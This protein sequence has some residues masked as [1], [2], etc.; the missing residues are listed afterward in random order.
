M[1]DRHV[2][3]DEARLRP[4]LV[5]HDVAGRHFAEKEHWGI[6]GRPDLMARRID[7]ELVQRA[8]QTEADRMLM[9]QPGR[10]DAIRRRQRFEQERAARRRA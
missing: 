9:S 5:R 3:I 10:M 4:V 1:P 8:A 2:S 7:E 6:E